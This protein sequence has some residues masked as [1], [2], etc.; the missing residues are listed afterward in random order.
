MICFNTNALFGKQDLI[1]I[2]YMYNYLF[3]IHT[4]Q[5]AFP[6]NTYVGLAEINGYFDKNI[7]FTEEINLPFR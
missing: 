3:K 5:Y 4:Y 2:T 7:N 6:I 1:D